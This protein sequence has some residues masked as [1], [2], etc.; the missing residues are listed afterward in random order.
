MKISEYRVDDVGLRRSSKLV[1]LTSDR[2]ELLKKSV[3]KF[4]N[5]LLNESRHT[6]E[7][8]NWG[9]ITAYGTKV[10]LSGDELESAVLA[11]SC[12]GLVKIRNF[13]NP[14]NSW[15]ITKRG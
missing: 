7:V 5:Y 6:G 11:L 4:W 1:P 13:G 14:V 3:S 10:N 8:Y 12:A 2:A 15:R 9:E